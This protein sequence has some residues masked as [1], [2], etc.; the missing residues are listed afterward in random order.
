MITW[1]AVMPTW[2]VIAWTLLGA[3][4]RNVQFVLDILLQCG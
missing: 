1:C 2:G 4:L 3:L